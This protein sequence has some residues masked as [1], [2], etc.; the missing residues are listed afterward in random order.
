[1]EEQVSHYS[2]IPTEFVD[3]D[4]LV[5][6]LVDLGFAREVIEIHQEARNLYGYH[7]DMRA[8]KANV[9]IRRQHIGSASNDLGFIRGSD[10]RFHAIISDF[11]SHRF[12]V[13]WQGQLKG[14]YVVNVGKRELKAKGFRTVK[15]IQD[16]AGRIHLVARRTR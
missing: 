1:M 14:R 6:A 9:I 15:E 7:G 3:E 16:E 11:D 13:L 4:A 5:Q 10:G 2:N 8:D 12:N